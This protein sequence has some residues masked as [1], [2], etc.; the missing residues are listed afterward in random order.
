MNKP[1]QV[2]KIKKRNKTHFNDTENISAHIKQVFNGAKSGSFLGL[3]TQQE[4]SL[5]LLLTRQHHFKY[6]RVRNLL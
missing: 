1:Q 2:K 5:T 6:L 4:F 3:T